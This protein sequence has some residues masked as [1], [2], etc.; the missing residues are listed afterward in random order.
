MSGFYTIEHYVITWQ[1]SSCEQGSYTCLFNIHCS[2]MNLVKEKH[3]GLIPTSLKRWPLKLIKHFVD[4]TR[5][6]P[7]HACPAGCCLLNFLN[8]LRLKFRVRALN[9]CCILWFRPDQS[10]VCNEYS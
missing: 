2:K 4:T 9:G 3:G 1:F 10:F 7:S 6:S 5:V 8:L